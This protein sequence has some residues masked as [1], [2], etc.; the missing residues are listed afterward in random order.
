MQ[1]QIN[2]YISYFLCFVYLQRIFSIYCIFLSSLINAILNLQKYD[3]YLHFSFISL[4]MNFIFAFKGI[5]HFNRFII[6]LN[7]QFHFSY[8]HR[9]NLLQNV[10]TK[11]TTNFSFLFKWRHGTHGEYVQTHKLTL[12]HIFAIITWITSRRPDLTAYMHNGS[13]LIEASVC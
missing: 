4:F 5:Y 1:K 6:A 10:D 13:G 11:R 12:I 2:K 8:H 9:T 3:F 7:S